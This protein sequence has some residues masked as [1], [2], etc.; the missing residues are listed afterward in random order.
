MQGKNLA[1]RLLCQVQGSL[2][3][4]DLSGS[5]YPFIEVLPHPSDFSALQVQETDFGSVP[6]DW[7]VPQTA[8]LNHLAGAGWE[9]EVGSLAT[10]KNLSGK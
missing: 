3:C 6:S 4:L 10:L 9:S 1:T 5:L 8:R 2:F 7:K